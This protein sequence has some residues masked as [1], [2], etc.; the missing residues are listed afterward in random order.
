MN[1]FMSTPPS[2][3][4]QANLPNSAIAAELAAA[5]VGRPPTDVRRFGAGA[6]HYVF[7]A[8][9]LDRAP[10]VVRIAAEHSRSAM[11]G[12]LRLSRL[13]R[14]RC[15]PLPEIIAEGVDQPFSHLV[16]ERLPGADLG[17]VVHGLSDSS[18]DVIDDPGRQ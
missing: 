16:L 17:E 12:A 8:S 3:A 4:A 18:V 11:A 15:V 1:V 14:P 6:H 2:R 7:E 10:V 13:L 5:A 9:F